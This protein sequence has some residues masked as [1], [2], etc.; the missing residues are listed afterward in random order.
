M[1]LTKDAKKLVY[2]LV[3]PAIIKE[4]TPGRTDF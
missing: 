1:F 3:Y 4:A 2:D